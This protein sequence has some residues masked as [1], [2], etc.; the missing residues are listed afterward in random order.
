MK[1]TNIVYWALLLLGMLL[2]YIFWG[3]T[4]QPVAFYGF[5]ETAE[6][7]VNHRDPLVVETIHVRPGDAVRAGEVLLEAKR[8]RDPKGAV[9]QPF[10]I[11]ELRSKEAVWKAGL[12]DELRVL[13]EKQKLA[14]QR[15]EQR[16]A[17]KREALAYQQEL[18]RGLRTLTENGTG[19]TTPLRTEIDQ[20]TRELGGLRA[21]HRLE[22]EQLRNRQNRARSPYRESM[23]RLAAEQAFEAEQLERAIQIVAPSNGL[24][25]NLHCE[26]TE[27]VEAYAPLLNFYEPNP[28]VVRG[29][30]HEDLRLSVALGDRF[31]VASLVDANSR[32]EG[33]VTGLGSRIVE[34]PARLRKM[35]DIRSYGREVTIQIP[36]DNRLLQ[37]EKIS[38]KRLGA[39]PTTAP[40]EA[41][42]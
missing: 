17:E 27:Y 40:L 21:T 14:E 37:K 25:G 12:A 4:H 23:K 29:Y 5:A 15:L 1:R 11:A 35:P 10:A 16:L 33:V 39:A 18:T 41:L 7:R 30:V 13:T 26:A 28:T 38:L 2:A 31:E 36:P 8:I 9:S 34:I 20:L 3:S 22:R 6:T 32:Y 19:T 24:V 42:K